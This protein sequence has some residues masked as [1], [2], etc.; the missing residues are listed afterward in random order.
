MLTHFK[1]AFPRLPVQK[2]VTLCTLRGCVEVLGIINEV[3]FPKNFYDT[4]STV[5][6]FNNI[7]RSGKRISSR[8][9]HF[10]ERT[11]GV[12]MSPLKWYMLDRISDFKSRYYHRP[13][14]VSKPDTGGSSRQALDDLFSGMSFFKDLP[15]PRPEKVRE[16]G[17]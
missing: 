9:T 4:Y 3:K 5:M 15:K 10:C 7:M 14:P 11:Y 13:K 8:A 16:E 6:A 1:K 2:F 17:N 12:Y